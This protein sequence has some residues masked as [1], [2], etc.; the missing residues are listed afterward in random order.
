MNS[1]TFII[2]TIVGAENKRTYIVR[3][4]PS[5]PNAP[6]RPVAVCDSSEELA[7]FF[8]DVTI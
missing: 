8:D 5:A 7:R 6:A 4:L 3:E 1:K 2:E